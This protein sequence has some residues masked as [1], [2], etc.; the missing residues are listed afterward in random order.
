MALLALN[1]EWDLAITILHIIQ[2]QVNNFWV[3]EVKM[4]EMIVNR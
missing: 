2:N 3:L 1:T 4:A